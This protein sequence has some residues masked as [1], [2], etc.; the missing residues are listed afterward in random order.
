[1]SFPF[2]RT[3]YLLWDSTEGQQG[4]CDRLR[5]MACGMA[6]AKR[7]GLRLRYRWET[8]EECP[9]NWDELFAAPVGLTFDES[10]TRR[11]T[12][13]AARIECPAN[14]PPYTFWNWLRQ[15]RWAGAFRSFEDFSSLWRA[16]IRSMRP[17]KR[18]ATAVNQLVRQSAGR[19]LV[20][21][22]LRRTEMLD[23]DHSPVNRENVAAYDAALWDEVIRI[24]NEHRAV[25]FFLA[26]DDEGYF[27]RWTERLH[28]LGLPLVAPNKQWGKAFRQTGMHDALTDLWLLG[29]CREVL[30]SMPS[31]F[32]KIS[33][34]LGAPHR[35]IAPGS[36]SFARSGTRL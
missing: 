27:I 31:G 16:S 30:G 34:A 3:K 28:R 35:I 8:N 7:L 24:A 20:G 22:H 23:A 18:T 11:L 33:E 12:N 13:G 36:G 29:R 21:I 25:C 17:V 1:M 14:I 19:P 2:L 32:L 6:L 9:A 10:S 5:G 4:L 26:A 15:T